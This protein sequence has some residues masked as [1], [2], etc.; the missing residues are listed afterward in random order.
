[1]SVLGEM[2][3]KI[4]LEDY[5]VQPAVVGHHA[6]RFGGRALD[7]HRISFLARKHKGGM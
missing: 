1:M 7:E 4:V 2:L 3:L 6:G 5:R